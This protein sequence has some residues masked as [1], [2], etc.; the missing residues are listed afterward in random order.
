MFSK[1]TTKTKGFLRH[2]ERNNSKKVLWDISVVPRQESREPCY[3]VV[4]LYDC[5]AVQNTVM[6]TAE[7]LFEF[8]V[9]LGN[10][11]WYCTSNML[12]SDCWTQRR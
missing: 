10:K 11:M 1:G 6:D 9:S 7:G 4:K 12:Y 8:G 2:F 5:I 3:P